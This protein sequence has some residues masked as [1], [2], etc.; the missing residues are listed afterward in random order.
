M[1]QKKF[2]RSVKN[3]GVRKEKRIFGDR[4]SRRDKTG[5]VRKNMRRDY[6]PQEIV[7]QVEDFP[8]FRRKIPESDCR[9]DQ[10]VAAGRI[11]KNRGI[12]SSRT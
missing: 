9:K 1:A 12:E 6:T 7:E 11:E 3:S 5:N 10:Q 4:K 2:F 8:E